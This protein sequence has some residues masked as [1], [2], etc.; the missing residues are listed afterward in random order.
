[1]LKVVIA[2]GGTGGHLFPAQQLAELLGEAEVHFAGH[3]LTSTPFFQRKAPFH[4]IASTGSL[5]KWPLLLKGLWQS[6]VLLS[7][8]KPDVVVG[9]GSF[10]S[11]PTLLAAVILR[12]K[13]VLFEAN[14]S[15]G[16]VNRFFAP[17]AEK[18]AFQFPIL[19]PKAVY[20]PLLPWVGKKERSK[21]YSHDLYREW[22]KNRE[23][24]QEAPQIFV[25]ERGAVFENTARSEG[26]KCGA[27][28]TP[29][30]PDSS[31]TSGIFTILVFGGSQGAAFINQTFC[32]AAKLLSFPFQVI[33]LTGKEA[34][35]IKY[36]APAIV[37]PFEEEMAAAY[38]AADLVVCRCGAGTTAELIRFTKP[39]IVIP[40]PY[41]HDHQRKNGEFLKEG[42]RLLLQKEA[43]A[44]RLAE[45]IEKARENLEFHREALRNIALPETID[46]GTVV[47]R[48]GERK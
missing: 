47:R 29:P 24:G 37:K 43:T 11:F 8:L 35:E 18:V 15:L 33:H 16:K 27:K 30:K 32:Q 5:K 22:L 1:M 26:Q 2:T 20:V 6:L 36:D 19:H 25:P 39:S 45:E 34:I 40:Y 41:A 13:I 12:K 38:E 3:K 44:K 31:T 10:H 9:F 7:R 17:F 4:E 28:P 46:F 21:T 48:V 42:T 14:C 23:F